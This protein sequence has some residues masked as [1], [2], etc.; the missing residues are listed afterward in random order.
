MFSWKK[1]Y[2][3]D[4]ALFLA[5]LFACFSGIVL[6]FFLPSGNYHLHAGGRSYFAAEVFKTFLGFDRHFW[7]I[8][9][10]WSSLILMFLIVLHLIGHRWWIASTTK[11][12]FK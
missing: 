6:G 12:F 4:L 1:N 7:K 8:L 10:I 2:F 11:K 3:L 9:H 5:F